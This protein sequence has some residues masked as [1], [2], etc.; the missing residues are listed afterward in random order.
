MTRPLRNQQMTIDKSKSVLLVT[1]PVNLFP[2]SVN[3]FK[4]TTKK[5]EGGLKPGKS[6]SS[7]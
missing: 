1:S 6:V 7:Q 3:Y 5:T 4:T 2:K